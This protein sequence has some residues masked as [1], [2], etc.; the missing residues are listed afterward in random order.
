MT[1]LKSL[2][3]LQITLSKLKFSD[4][5]DLTGQIVSNKEKIA[6]L[7]LTIQN[8]IVRIEKLNKPLP[9]GGECEHCR[10]TIS[11]E[12]REICQTKISQELQETKNDVQKCKKEITILSGQNV[13]HQQD[14]LDLTQSK[15]KLD[16][17]NNQ[18]VSKKTEMIDKRGLYDEYGSLLD[19]FKL[20]LESKKLEIIQLNEDLKFSSLE[21]AKIIKDKINAEK[22]KLVSTTNQIN[23]INKDIAHFTS[24][25][26]VMSHDLKQKEED[27]KKK[28]TFT[29]LLS[30]IENKLVIYP[31]VIQGFSSS[32][33]PN[34]IIQNVLDDLQI[35]A[36]NLLAQ[37][38]PGLQLSFSIEKTNGDGVETDTLDI[39][40]TVN[41]KK[42][43][44]EN[45]SGAMQLA[46]NFSLKL[47]LS[48]F[49]Q[50][51]S[52]VD[53]KFLLLDEID[54][55]MDKASVDFFADIV[56]FLQKDYTILVITHNDSLKNKF[57]NM[58]LVNQ[59][60]NLVSKARVVSSW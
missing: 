26:A 42:R 5:V 35:E 56:K 16:N 33:I 43:Y 59:D 22:I 51:M 19:K 12:H 31:S 30:A 20:E 53:V 54:P 52:G 47:G 36:N 9:I 1:E 60:S 44:Y 4:I 58:I 25:K 8:D 55:A 6:Q 40:Y 13:K 21:E 41:G 17:I 10:Q 23:L 34:L 18:I 46:V 49:L 7:N 14:I 24:Q 32:G 57:Q 28:N 37:L 39:N 11:K 3:G 27:K 15:N 38:K 45:I 29:T 48:F 50:K 2:E